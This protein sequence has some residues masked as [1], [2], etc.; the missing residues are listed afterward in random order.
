MNKIIAGF[1]LPIWYRL[2]CLCRIKKHI[3]FVVIRGDK[4]PS[5]FA[6]TKKYIK[7]DD[8][9]KEYKRVYHYF[10][11]GKGTKLK[12][13]GRCFSLMPKLARA[14]YVFVSDGSNII[15]NLKLRKGTKLIQTWHGCGAL[16]KFG[17]DID[18]SKRIFGN[19]DI[20]TVSSEQVVPVY[21]KAMG[22]E[23]DKIKAVGVPHTDIYFSD[24]FKKHCQELKEDVLAGRSKRIVLYAP[25][26]RG[27]ISTPK[28]ASGLNLD[29][30]YKHLNQEYI[31]ISKLHPLLKPVKKNYRHKDFYYDVSSVWTIEEALM[32]CDILITDYSSVIFDYSLL[33]KPAL[34]YAFDL[35][36]YEKNIGFYLDYKSQIPGTVCTSTMDVIKEIKNGCYDVSK[37]KKF[38]EDYMSACDGEATHRLMEAVKAL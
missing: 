25:T 4:L 3:L 9:L 23:Q 8:E 38:K 33:N 10:T 13:A 29:I 11:L 7:K 34:F 24:G 35:A 28:D 20:V 31:V 27:D 26:F 12:Y 1:I 15:T 19:E 14:K 30:M 18:E 17:C 22:L 21:S 5:D 37:M 2:C 36:E 32:V 6:M 16:K